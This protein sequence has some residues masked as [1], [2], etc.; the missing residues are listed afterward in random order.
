MATPAYAINALAQG[1][2]GLIFDDGAGGD[3]GT[4]VD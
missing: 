2:C 1:V 3:D 4:E